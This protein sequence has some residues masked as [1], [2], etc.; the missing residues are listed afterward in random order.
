MTYTEF[1]EDREHNLW[2]ATTKGI[3]MLRDLR[4]TTISKREG[5]SL[6]GVE[7]V[8]AARDGTVWIGS[9]HL[10]ALRPDGVI[11]EPENGLPGNQITSLLED[12]A[13]RLW[14]GSDNS[15]WVYQVGSSA[16]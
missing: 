4:V 7:S 11:S 2:I 9:S 10:Q 1:F 15:L 16:P 8:L 12:H 14:V 6:D 3:D 13:G 5:L